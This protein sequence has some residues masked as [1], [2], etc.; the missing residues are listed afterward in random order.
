MIK[1]KDKQE[2]FL[3]GIIFTEK[4]RNFSLTYFQSK[5]TEHLKASAFNISRPITHPDE[6]IETKTRRAIFQITPS[7]LTFEEF[8]AVFGM[9]VDTI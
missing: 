9:C 6:M 8:G 1:N 3:I 5:Q 2:V 4:K 7:A